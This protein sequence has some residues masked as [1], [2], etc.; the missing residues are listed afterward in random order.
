MLFVQGDAYHTILD[1]KAVWITAAVAAAGIGTPS[2]N[3]RLTWAGCEFL[4]P[5]YSSA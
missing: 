1:I 5:R 3:H 2:L 4:P